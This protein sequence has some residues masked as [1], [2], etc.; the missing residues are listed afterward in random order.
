MASLRQF[1]WSVDMVLVDEYVEYIAHLVVLN[2]GL[3]DLP[4]PFNVV[5]HNFFRICIKV[6][7]I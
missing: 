7:P 6:V 1:Q 4:Y 2:W 3:T 5:C